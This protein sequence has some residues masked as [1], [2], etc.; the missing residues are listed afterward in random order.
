MNRSTHPNLVNRDS[1]ATPIVRH[2]GSMTQT[3]PSPASQYRLDWTLRLEELATKHNVTGAQL[4]V[5]AVAD[6][7][8]SDI[9]TSVSGTLNQR[10]GVPASPDS[11]FEIGSISK[12]WTTVLVMQ[13]IDDGL[14]E[15]DTPVRSVLPDFALADDDAASQVTVRQ[16]L[17]HTSGI[18][19]DLFVDT[20]RGDDAVENYVGTLHAAA[21]IHPVGEG[22]SYCNSG[23]VIAGRIVETLRGQTWDEALHTHLIK[24][25]GLQHTVTLAEQAI[26]H[27]VAVGHTVDASGATTPSPVWGIARSMGP[28]GSIVST[29]HDQL[30]FATALWHDGL[31]EN[32]VRILSKEKARLM[33]K[34]NIELGDRSHRFSGWGLG[35]FF[36]D[37]SSEITFGHDGGTIAQ[38]AY[39]RI[40]PEA[41]LLLCLLTNAGDSGNLLYRDL[42]SEIAA[43]VGA[44]PPPVIEPN[45]DYSSAEVDLSHYAGVYE[46]G[47]I[48]VTVCVEDG[49][50]RMAIT[51][52]LSL[53]PTVVPGETTQWE[54]QPV[55]AGTFAVRDEIIPWWSE[56]VF[57]SA[58]GG[59]YIAYGHRTLRKAQ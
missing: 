10:T 33:R 42:F 1:A 21:L 11:L 38:R 53:D 58:R 9:A 41:G 35:W 49:G 51:E 43:E 6:G 31:A 15:L 24:P 28:A 34:V 8:L 55:A 27:S 36:E 20:G 39:L 32:G 16:L 47:A 59:D 40:L 45:P 18:D 56:V 25:L 3:A 46:S 54:L 2:D 22:F 48:T 44:G 17:S 37:W 52:K 19:G 50:L 5:R 30:V 7:Q 23:F 29:V 12:V 4:G 14:L 13:L 26:L 57:F